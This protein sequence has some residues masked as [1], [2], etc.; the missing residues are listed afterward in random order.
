MVQ[1]KDWHNIDDWHSLW[2]HPILLVLSYFLKV[3][4]HEKFGP[5]FVFFSTFWEE[6]EG[7][8]QRKP[9]FADVERHLHAFAHIN[10]LLR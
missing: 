10:T 2:N 9:P 3:Q 4:H 7:E 1:S 6:G 8:D 5:F